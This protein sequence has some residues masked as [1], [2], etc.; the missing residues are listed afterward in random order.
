M[1]GGK[2]MSFLT[3]VW[4]SGWKLDSLLSLINDVIENQWQHAVVLVRI[5][6]PPP[7]SLCMA[8]HMVLPHHIFTMRSLLQREAG[9]QMLPLAVCFDVNAPCLLR[10]NLFITVSICKKQFRGWGDMTFLCLHWWWA[11]NELRWINNN[12][13]TWTITS[14]QLKPHIKLIIWQICNVERCNNLP[15][16]VDSRA[17]NTREQLHLPASTSARGAGFGHSLKWWDQW[18]CGSDNT[19]ARRWD[20]YRSVAEYGCSWVM[21]PQQV[22]TVDA[23][24]S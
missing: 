15:A 5:Q 7:A 18:G 8:A 23:R 20:R 21:N 6:A 17:F 14:I 4:G 24:E 19:V 9:G 11:V 16:V 2:E 1:L 13:S 12:R 3:W 22:G 10:N